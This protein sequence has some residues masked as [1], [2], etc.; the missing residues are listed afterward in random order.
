MHLKIFKGK[1]KNPTE[2]QKANV[3]KDV[4]KA[5]NKCDFL[6]TFSKACVWGERLH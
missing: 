4:Y 5:N 3:E 1:E 6:K 2:S